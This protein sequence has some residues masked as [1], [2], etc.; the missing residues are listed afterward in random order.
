[1]LNKKIISLSN[2][3][4]YSGI[5]CQGHTQ[6]IKFPVLPMFSS[7]YIPP[8]RATVLLMESLLSNEVLYIQSY[9]VKT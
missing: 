8:V 3:I 4:S 7:F 6:L 1:M 9:W 5:E 2:W